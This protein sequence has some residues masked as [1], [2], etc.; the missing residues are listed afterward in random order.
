MM[1]H[2]SVY[3]DEDSLTSVCRMLGVA[4]M[5]EMF[6]IFTFIQSNRKKFL[7]N[8]KYWFEQLEVLTMW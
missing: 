6:N 8:K 2:Y 7:Y 3:S 1:L 4:K 5:G